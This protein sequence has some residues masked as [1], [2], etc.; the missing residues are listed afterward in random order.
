M[1]FHRSLAISAITLL[2]MVGSSPGLAVPPADSGPTHTLAAPV[3]VSVS[4]TGLQIVAAVSRTG[5]YILGSPVEY[6]R[7]HLRDLETDTLIKRLPKG[8]GGPSMS[9]NGRYVSYS[10]PVG[11]WGRRKV[12]VYDR[13]TGRTKE[14]TTK[15]NGSTLRPSWRNRCTEPLCE[16]DQKLV[17]SPQL[18]GGQIS[19][20]GRYVTF[21]GNFRKPARIDLYVKDLRS[22]RLQSFKGA[23]QPL[24]AEGDTEQLQAPTVSEDGNT[25]L[26]A[27][28]LVSYEDGNTWGPGRAL[29]D[30]SRLV[31]IGG[32]GN[33]M[34]RDGLTLTINGAFTGTDEGTPVG[35]A[36]YDVATGTSVPAD[37]P[38]LRMNLKN[39]SRDGRYV[40]WKQDYVAPLQI[41]DRTSA[42]DYDLQ[43]ALEAAG[44]AL[45][46]TAGAVGNGFVWGHSDAKSALSG[47]GQ[48]AF[49]RTTVGIVAIRWTP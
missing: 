32:V 24:V 44:Y 45:D 47:D 28:R 38:T 40:L 14:A 37:P 33:T 41:R 2:G 39:S 34:T 11:D 16:E 46:S 31:E 26:L 29:F 7:V 23:C 9:D 13:R 1:R 42:I 18:T 20:N 48:V 4:P 30:R 3:T 21:C 25:I 22:K 8:A 49:V 12:L 10:L 27:G 43:A 19:G 17:Y 15:T 35:V 36:W 6:G 5:R